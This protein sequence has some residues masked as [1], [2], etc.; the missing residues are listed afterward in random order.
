ML[1]DDLILRSAVVAKL[2]ELRSELENCYMGE[3]D[4]IRKL[5]I[6]KEIADTR[7]IADFV[8]HFPAAG[9]G[10]ENHGQENEL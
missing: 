5:I 8:R 9:E 7:V 2:D 10:R 6:A 1:N 4:F 3:L